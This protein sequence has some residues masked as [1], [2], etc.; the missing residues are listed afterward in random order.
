MLK[1]IGPKVIKNMEPEQTNGGGVGKS[2]L[3]LVV[4]ILIVGGFVLYG[5]KGGDKASKGTIKI[6][7]ILPLTGDAAAYG[8]AA[9]NVL[10]LAAEEINQNGGINGQNLEL[11]I[12][13]GKCN[14]KDAASAM[15][16]L[17]N[18]DKTK[19]VIGGFCSGES[20]AAVPVAT[21]SKVV[22]LSPGSSSPDLT[23]VSPYFFRIFPSDAGQGELDAKAANEKKW[24]TIA[25]IQEQAEYTTGIQ[26]VFTARFEEL[27][28]KTVVEGFSTGVTDFRSSLA[29]LK[30]QKPDALFVNSNG[31]ANLGRILKQ[32]KEM[33]WTIPL[34]LNE[35]ILGDAKSIEENKSLLEGAIG[36]EFVA[37][38][39]NPKY[40]KLLES[41]KQKYEQDLPF[42][43]YAHTEYDAV[44]IARDGIMTVGNDG[45]KLATWSRT[46]KDWDG[47]SGKVTIKP[48]GDRESGYTPRIV[49]DG[50]VEVAQ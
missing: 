17:A 21:E 45:E 20:L 50:K 34:L 42:Q 27:G 23:G 43:N 9:R 47:A 41:Y 33:N 15:Q 46:I 29:K 2:I 31:S 25:F 12:E 19:F 37:D 40:Q 10:Q 48:D 8:E 49:H 28:G 18:V 26:K 35:A 39:T 4:L 7:A 24:K 14:G 11:I 13:D 30:S 32:V 6:G 1:Y 38:A 22:L 16:K 44:Y 36:V 3:W 5:S